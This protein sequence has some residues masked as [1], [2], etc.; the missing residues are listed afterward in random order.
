MGDETTA[1]AGDVTATYVET[2][3]ERQIR[4]ERDGRTAVIAQNRCG[5]AMLAVRRR[6]DGD[7]LERYYGLDMAIDHAAELLGLRPDALPVPTAGADLG[8]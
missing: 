7:E 5:Y 6:P 3:S 1:R 2:A 4:F 8:M